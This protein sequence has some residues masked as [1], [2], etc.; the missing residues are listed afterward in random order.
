M[1]LTKLQILQRRVP[2][3]LRALPPY[4][5]SKRKLLGHIA[6]LLPPPEKAPVLADAFAGS[7]AL[8]MWAKRRGFRAIGNDISFRSL[9]IGKALL[10]NDRRTLS[11]E[12]ILQV[13]APDAPP[14]CDFTER[15]HGGQV[16]PVAHARVVDRILDCASRATGIK[17][18]LLRLLAYHFVVSLR[19]MSNF[20]AR[21]IT[22]QLE[23]RRFEE[24]NPHFLR[25]RLVRRLESHPLT[26]LEEIRRRINS[27]VFSNARRNEMRSG[28]AI[29]FLSQVQA[30]VLYADPPY[31]GTSS[32]QSSYRH[33]DSILQRDVV[34]SEHSDFSS[35][36]GV[37]ALDRLL[38]ASRHIPVI[39][40]SYG[41]A[42][43][44]PEDL[45]ALV[46]KHRS[47]V[48]MET[49]AYKH[50]P[51]LASEESKARNLEVLIRAE[52]AK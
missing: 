52:R 18:W 13:F 33:L 10:E 17:K 22:E 40:L 35:R 31:A 1:K 45:Q 7:C 29:A 20:G 43:I 50:L 15:V 37:E 3:Y 9:V 6:R 34:D 19:P 39:V 32:Y 21:R 12:D 47:R 8:A 48:H 11:R 44:P 14:S 41:N 36:H 24:V 30:D 25:D 16:I 42:T 5:G 26:V 51:S 38:E 28:D 4:Q 49:I 27:S 2:G 23:H 46:A